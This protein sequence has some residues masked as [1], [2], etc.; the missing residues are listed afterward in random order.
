MSEM[1]FTDYRE[2]PAP[3]LDLSISLSIET[4]ATAKA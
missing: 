4:I 2:D 3:Y 1:V